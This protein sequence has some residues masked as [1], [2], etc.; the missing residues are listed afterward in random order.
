M[1]L[2]E[3]DHAE[4]IKYIVGSIPEV[5]Q[6][7]YAGLPRIL[8]A[9]ILKNELIVAGD[10]RKMICGTIGN[11]I[12]SEPA[13]N[14]IGCFKWTLEDSFF[15]SKFYE[16]LVRSFYKIKENEHEEA[17]IALESAVEKLQKANQLIIGFYG[18]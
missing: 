17:L 6:D 3:T 15:N 14:A 8:T 7:K 11:F 13:E 4:F 2:N 5:A 1:K 10:S 9:I 12:K 18:H 16:E